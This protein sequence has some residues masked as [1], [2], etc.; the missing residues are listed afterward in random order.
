MCEREGRVDS[1]RTSAPR[2]HQMNLASCFPN[3][4]III[5]HR[6]RPHH[7]TIGALAARACSWGGPKYVNQQKYSFGTGQIVDQGVCIADGQLLNIPPAPG[8]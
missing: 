3:N 4:I 2:L 8:H 6:H 7:I 5:H 1:W